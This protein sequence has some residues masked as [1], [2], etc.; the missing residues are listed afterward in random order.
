MQKLT[1]SVDVDAPVSHVWSVMLDRETYEEWAAAFYEG[2]TY[3]GGW[4]EGDTIRFLGPEDDETTG[5]LVAVVEANRPNEFV[6]LRYTAEFDHGVEKTDSPIVGMKES[7]SF[8]DTAAGTTVDVVLELPEEWAPM[9]SEMWPPALAQLK[10]V[11]E[12]P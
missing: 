3:D 1:F 9:M 7:Y 10:R 12:R 11:A 8:S 4:N 5:G 6:S 2:S